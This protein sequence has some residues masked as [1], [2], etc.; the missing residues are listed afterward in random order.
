[1]DQRIYNRG[2]YRMGKFVRKSHGQDRNDQVAKLRVVNRIHLME[3]EVECLVVVVV[4]AL[5][6]FLLQLEEC[7]WEHLQV[8]W[9][10]IYQTLKNLEYFHQAAQVCLVAE[11]LEV[12]QTGERRRPGKYNIVIN[13]SI[14]TL[15]YSLNH[16]Y[17]F[18]QL[19][20]I[21][22]CQT[23]LKHYGKIER[24]LKQIVTQGHKVLQ[25]QFYRNYFKEHNIV[26]ITACYF[27][28]I[29][30]IHTNK[31]NLNYQS[32]IQYIMLGIDR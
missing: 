15:S 1:M 23:M 8:I 13:R 2:S 29:V 24:T 7:C 3:S 32:E 4:S 10:L 22:I 11:V 19:A 20:M 18:H 28:F 9:V 25:F 6:C 31:C 21:F 26:T 5:S 16:L 12:H 30:Q 17:L 27:C 14:P